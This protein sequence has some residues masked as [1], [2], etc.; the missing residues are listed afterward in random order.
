M[1]PAGI[2]GI[3]CAVFR[4]H[5][6][7]AS[8][9]VNELRSGSSIRTNG[10]TIGSAASTSMRGEGRDTIPMVPMWTAPQIVFA[11]NTYATV[12]VTSAPPTAN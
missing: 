5:D 1:F 11:P 12:A 10:P 6:I 8:T 4:R 2:G 9:D 3:D 7:Q